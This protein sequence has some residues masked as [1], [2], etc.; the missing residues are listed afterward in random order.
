MPTMIQMRIIIDGMEMKMILWLSSLTNVN[1]NYGICDILHCFLPF[2][3]VR[4]QGIECLGLIYMQNI[5]P[6]LVHHNLW[7]CKFIYTIV[8]GLVELPQ[9]W[10]DHIFFFIRAH[11]VLCCV[12]TWIIHLRK[13]KSWKLN[14]CQESWGKF[15][16][17]KHNKH[18]RMF[19][20][21]LTVKNV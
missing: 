7:Q 14:Q 21:I 15:C 3:K 18:C 16:I 1:R 9:A 11:K 8:A 19:N 12:N 5:T 4:F 20:W 2:R 10:L 17:K 13:Q 6:W